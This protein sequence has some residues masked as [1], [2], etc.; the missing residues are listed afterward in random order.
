LNRLS[1][2]K[3]VPSFLQ[4]G[5]PELK[6]D[7]EGECSKDDADKGERISLGGG[8]LENSAS[9][10]EIPNRVLYMGGTQFR[11]YSGILMRGKG[12]GMR[13]QCRNVNRCRPRPSARRRLLWGVNQNCK[14]S[15]LR[16]GMIQKQKHTT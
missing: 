7:F 13:V 5:T 11:T 8:S 12:K 3:K 6:S 10:S 14:L 2:K 1:L 9:F 16:S 15:Q 4:K